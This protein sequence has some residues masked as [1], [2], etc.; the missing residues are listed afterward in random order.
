[1]AKIILGI[2]G[3]IACGKG[4]I[5]THLAKEYGAGTHRFSTMLRD[6]LDRM[7]IDQTRD[8]LALI[9][10]ILRHNFGEDVMAKTMM[11]E[12]ESDEH[13]IVIID[14]VRRL[15]DIKYLRELPHFKLVYVEAD[16]NKR[17]ERIIKRGEN[18]DDFGKTFEEFQK[19]QELESEKQIRDL[20]N[21]ADYAVD[22]NGTYVELY[23]QIDK[24]IKES[25]K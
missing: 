6:V 23:R 5:T 2:T 10:K 15:A 8:N 7:Y 22:N 19:E 4:T 1:M 12:A 24:I 17:Y 25:E 11:K 3:E 21:Y 13:E 9:S 14:G 20:K 16:I 18:T